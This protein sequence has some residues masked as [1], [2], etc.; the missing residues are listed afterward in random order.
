MVSAYGSIDLSSQNR[1]RAGQKEKGNLEIESV[2]AAAAEASCPSVP[3]LPPTVIGS[4]AVWSALFFVITFFAQSSAPQT[5]YGSKGVRTMAM[6]QQVGS[7]ADMTYPRRPFGTR[8]GRD[9]TLPVLGFPSVAL[10]RMS[11]A[12]DQSTAN[13]AVRHAVEDLGIRYFDV[14]PEYGDGVAQECLGPALKPHRDGVFLAAKT[15]Y[16]D[17]EGSAAD[18]ANTLRALKTDHLDLYQFHSISTEEDVETILGEG[19]AMETFQK[20]REEG[21][22]KAIGFSAHSEPMAVRMIESGL[23]DT[24]MFPINFAAYHYGGIGQKVLDSAKK[25]GVGVIALKAG[26]RG[27]LRPQDG[28][29]VHVPEAFHHIPEWKR[30][31]MVNFPVVTSKD[32][33]TCWYEPEDDPK[34][35]NRLILWSL[36]QSG[37]TAVLPPGDLNLLDGVALMLRGKSEV[38]P[39]DDANSQHM[40]DRYNDIVPIFHNRDESGTKVS[41]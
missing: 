38:P 4:I 21:K 41:T 35:L 11:S 39:F 2:S 15:M 37:V 16:R 33:P 20:A 9:V 17:A 32:H 34:E 6:M 3:S 26:A 19:G 25:N 36:N 29:A 7:E 1:E 23:V 13:E 12:S 31:E 30:K 27:R 5:T 40:L 8:N 28:D 22:I 10:A 18:L 14:A 24:C